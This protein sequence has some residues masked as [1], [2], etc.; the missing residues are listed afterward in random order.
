MTLSEPLPNHHLPAKEDDA[1]DVLAAAACTYERFAAEASRTAAASPE[2]S[3]FHHLLAAANSLAENDTV[4]DN[5]V[6]P[7]SPERLRIF[8]HGVDQSHF[9][10]LRVLDDLVILF[11]GLMH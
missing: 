8:P 4:S 3:A 6:K 10:Y 11:F 5:V 1:L 9:N 2:A 7:K